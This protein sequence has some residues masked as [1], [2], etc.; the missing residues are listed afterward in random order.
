MDVIQ[1]EDLNYERSR[2]KQALPNKGSQQENDLARFY[3]S[4]D[5]F[6]AEREK[7]QSQ[8]GEV[9]I[10]TDRENSLTHDKADKKGD[11]KENHIAIH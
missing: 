7:L 2:T 4:K 6:E 8:D 9:K 10:N 1:N 5:K 3:F 11:L